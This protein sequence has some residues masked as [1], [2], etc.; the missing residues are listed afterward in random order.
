MVKQLIPIGFP[1]GIKV[2]QDELTEGLTLEKVIELTKVYHG[3]HYVIGY[4]TLYVEKPHYHIHFL[5]AKETSVNAMKTFRSNVI[6]KTFPHI[7]KSF[8]F[9][10]GQDLPSANVS[11]WFAY[12]LKEQTQLIS[13]IEVTEQMIIEAKSH[14]EVKKLKKIHSEKK[15]N[16]IKEKKEFK[17]KMYDYIK[18]TISNYDDKGDEY[19]GNE[20]LAF[21]VSCIKFLMDNEKYGSMKKLFLRQYY[22]EW[23]IKHSANRWT[24][25]DIYKYINNN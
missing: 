2:N 6:K 22:L 9:Y 20:H 23:K 15:S 18:K 5:S 7:S 4:D 8:R 11:N 17:D 19:Y 14:L 21:D 24:E 16:D 10:T 3:N 13:N 1:L 25:I 12:A